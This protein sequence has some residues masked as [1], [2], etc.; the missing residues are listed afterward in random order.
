MRPLLIL[1]LVFTSCSAPPQPHSNPTQAA[2]T[3][4]P[5]ENSGETKA[6]PEQSAPPPTPSGPIN[7]PALIRTNIGGISI[8]AVTFDSRSHYLAVAD[9]AGGPGSVWPD[10]RAAGQASGAIAAINAGFFTP[11]GAPLGKVIAN[12]KSAGSINRASSLGAGFY[13]RSSSGNMSLIRRDR[14]SSGSQA[15]QSGPFLVE[16]GSSVSGLSEKQSC[17][18]SFVA[19]D[20]G[21]RWTIAITGSC[22]LKGL[23]SALE[24]QSIGGTRL[25]TVL[26]LDGGRS[27]EMCASN[28]VNGGSF[29]ERPLWNKPVPNFLVLKPKN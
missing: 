25:K 3:S 4:A 16:N 19:H 8:D 20:G 9:Q 26:N 18:R 2:I 13:V 15:L 14:F 12:G 23:A 21:S 17:A 27:S 10:S 11:E 24:G 1:A 6:T 22:S 5:V 28:S 7:S 29:F